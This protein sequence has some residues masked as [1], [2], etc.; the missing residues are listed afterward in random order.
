[1]LVDSPY[2]GDWMGSAYS[3]HGRRIDYH[4]FLHPNGTYERSHRSGPD[5]ERVDRGKWRHE[6]EKELLLLESDPPIRAC[7]STDLWS[8]LSV[9]TCEHSN[10]LMVLREVKFAGRNLPILFYRVHL[11]G[12][13]YSEQLGIRD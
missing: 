4:L 7:G 9:N 10:C 5:Y 11:P 13:W 6:A 1:M 12:R 3:S 8:V 2:V